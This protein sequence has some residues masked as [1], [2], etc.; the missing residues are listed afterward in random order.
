MTGG[1]QRLII[2]LCFN[3]IIRRIVVIDFFREFL[4]LYYELP[5]SLNC[6]CVGMQ[7]DV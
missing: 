2:K 3:I 6:A 1:W 4:F 7:I 5:I